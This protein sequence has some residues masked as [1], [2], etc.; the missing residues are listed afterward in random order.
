[1]HIQTKEGRGWAGSKSWNKQTSSS[2]MDCSSSDTWTDEDHVAA[3]NEWTL[4]RCSVRSVCL[5]HE[6]HDAPVLTNTRSFYSS[7]LLW[8]EHSCD[9]SCAPFTADVRINKVTGMPSP[10]N[11]TLEMS[12]TEKKSFLRKQTQSNV[13]SWPKMATFFQ[14]YKWL[15]HTQKK[16]DVNL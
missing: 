5:L 16:K 7:G 3:I 11:W 9:T 1:M 8:S 2:Y 10:T 4:Q 12:I 15:C 14:M 13:N 6:I